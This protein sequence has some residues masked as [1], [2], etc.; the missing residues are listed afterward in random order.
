[1]SLRVEALTRHTGEP[2]A[3]RARRKRILIVTGDRANV[4][5]SGDGRVQDG[6]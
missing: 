4:F 5:E 3:S 1:M 6:T 2:D